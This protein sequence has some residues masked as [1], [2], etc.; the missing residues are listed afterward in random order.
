MFC[1]GKRLNHGYFD[2]SP[3][4]SAME[5]APSKPGESQIGSWA[6]PTFPD[7]RDLLG[8]VDEVMVFRGS[9]GQAEMSELY[10]MVRP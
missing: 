8:W 6:K 9:L 5:S 7:Q 3:D 1:D 10:R 4:G 2:N